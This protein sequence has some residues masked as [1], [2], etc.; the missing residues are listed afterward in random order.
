[1]GWMINNS[2]GKPDS[3]LTFAVIGALTTVAAIFLPMVKKIELL[4]F[5]FEPSGVAPDATIVTAFLGAT[6]LAYVNRR[7]QKLDAEIKLK[8]LEVKAKNGVL[9]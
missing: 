5:V 7:K 1:M 4:T 9:E 2:A 3:M 6:L 8:E